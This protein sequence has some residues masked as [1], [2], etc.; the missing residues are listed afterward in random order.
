MADADAAEL[1]RAAIEISEAAAGIP[2]RYFHSGVSVE[3]KPDES[4]VT[5]ADRET[6]AFIRQAIEQRFPSHGIFGEEFGRK[7]GSGDVT[8]VIDPIDGTKA[9]I[10]GY[11]LF[12]M[13]LG[14]MRNGRVAAGVINM[15][16]L[17]ECIGGAPGVGAT[18][19]GK[20]IRCRTLPIAEATIFINGGDRMLAQK[21]DVLG[22]L[23][24]VGKLRRFSYDCYPFALVAAGEIDAVVD[25]G[26]QPY[27]YL[28]PAGLVEG[29]GGMM[30]DW[31][32]RPLGL[33]SD[34]A[35]LAAGS[36]ELHAHLLELVG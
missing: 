29:A 13:L 21:P 35:V 1:L 5:I 3:D 33:D 23:L 27:D 34:G 2:R 19:N 20:P 10:S 32:G 24:R 15:P 6:E 22:R 17:R 14:A 11:P 7:E 31:R 12:G 8:W 16:A 25:F 26:L 9:F 30:T 36:R 4:P 28:G 18:R